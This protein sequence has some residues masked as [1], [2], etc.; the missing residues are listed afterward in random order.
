MQQDKLVLLV[1]GQIY[2]GWQ[3]VSVQTGIDRIA[4]SFEISITERWPQQTV[5]WPIPPG[6]FCEVEIGGEPVINGYV[7]SVSTNY[8][9]GQHSISVSGRDRTGDLVDCSA[10]SKSY[11]GLSFISIARELCKPYNIGVLDESGSGNKPIPKFAVQNGESVFN[12]LEKLARQIGVLLV[13][14]RRGGL[15]ITRGGKSG[16]ASEKLVLGKNILSASIENNA[17]ELFSSITVKG[18]QSGSG[19]DT[20]DVKA[21][22]PSAK[23]E[24]A[25]PSSSVKGAVTRHRP[26]VIVAEN[27][28]DAARCKQ[29]AE[30]EAGHRE[31]LSKKINI[32]VQGWRQPDGRLWQINQMATIDC[33]WMRVDGK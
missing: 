1:G 15:I 3:S 7:D 16:L 5:D 2:S 29:R 18:Q 19:K 14:N 26:L 8:D 9:A 22:G 24:L 23:V 10:P 25:A 30:W 6:E 13:S 12:T 32:N 33:P 20:Y 4:G 11:S 31:A 27:Q 21:A 28:A 17:T